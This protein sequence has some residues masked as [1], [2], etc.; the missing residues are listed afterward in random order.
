M[1]FQRQ[2]F[3]L[4]AHRLLLHLFILFVNILQYVAYEEDEIE[5]VWDYLPQQRATG[6]QWITAACDRQLLQ[7]KTSKWERP[8]I[9][10]VVFTVI[11]KAVTGVFFLSGLVISQHTA[12]QKFHWLLFISIQTALKRCASYVASCLK[13]HVCFSLSL[14]YSTVYHE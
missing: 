14:H 9:S 12:F 5:K 7:I 13:L 1:R 11:G 2:L 3:P 8:Q 6:L 4:P 10:F